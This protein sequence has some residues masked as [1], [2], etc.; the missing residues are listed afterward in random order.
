MDGQKT[1]SSIDHPLSDHWETLRVN[2]KNTTTLLLSDAQAK[3]EFLNS[4][5]KVASL[6]LLSRYGSILL[7]FLVVLLGYFVSLGR[8]LVQ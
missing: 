4:H 3:D 2:L 1:G 6:P 5:N 7:I 8:T